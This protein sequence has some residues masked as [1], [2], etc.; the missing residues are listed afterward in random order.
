MYITCISGN[1]LKNLRSS[2]SLRQNFNVQNVF[3]SKSFLYYLLLEKCD[4]SK[5][6]N[7]ATLET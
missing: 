3:N 1:E 7:Y 4:L 2:K 6:T 5:R